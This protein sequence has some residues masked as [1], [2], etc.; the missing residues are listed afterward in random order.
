MWPIGIKE[1]GQIDAHAAK[2][3]WVATQSANH[4]LIREFHSQTHPSSCC[5]DR[6]HK[7]HPVSFEEYLSCFSRVRVISLLSESRFR[8]HERSA[9]LSYTRYKKSTPPRYIGNLSHTGVVHK[10]DQLADRF[11]LGFCLVTPPCFL[12][13]RFARTRETIPSAQVNRHTH[14]RSGTRHR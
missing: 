1:R 11:S 13:Q 14:K 4:I 2:R 6:V 7:Q 5:G 10:I 12:R 9:H 8:C 3:M